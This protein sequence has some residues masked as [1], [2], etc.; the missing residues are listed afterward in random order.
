M[1]KIIRFLQNFIVDK[2]TIINQN[3]GQKYVVAFTEFLLYS[4]FVCLEFLKMFKTLEDI[5]LSHHLRSSTCYRFIERPNRRVLL[6]LCLYVGIGENIFRKSSES[7][8]LNQKK[9]K[10]NWRH[11]VIAEVLLKLYSSLNS[12]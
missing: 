7:H 11:C 2:W 3:P 8:I 12:E 9:I 6:K 5:V 10:K 1:K 4:F